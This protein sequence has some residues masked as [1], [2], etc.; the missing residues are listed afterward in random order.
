[1]GRIYQPKIKRKILFRNSNRLLD[2]CL[3]EDT[4]GDGTGCDNMT[5]VLIKI[6]DKFH[7]NCPIEWNEN[8]Q[9]EQTI[10]N[11]DLDNESNIIKI[12]GHLNTNMSDGSSRL[13]AKQV[14]NYTLPKYKYNCEDKS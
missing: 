8:L 10:D 2:E 12:T 1:M 11:I 13:V 6:G 5:A 7:Q 9:T 4:K 14:P 3:A